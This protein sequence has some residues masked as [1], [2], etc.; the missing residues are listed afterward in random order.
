MHERC[1]L[2]N[3]HVGL[4]GIPR[5]ISFWRRLES[6][7]LSVSISAPGWGAQRG[8]G[9]TN[10]DFLKQLKQRGIRTRYKRCFSCNEVERA[11]CC[12]GIQTWKN[13]VIRV[14]RSKREFQFAA[15]VRFSA[16]I[17]WVLLRH[18][19]DCKMVLELTDFAQ[20]KF[21]SLKKDLTN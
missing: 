5:K 16:G 12:S 20:G 15:G 6:V 4:L 21:F 19:P 3:A 1:I 18:A 13:N 9:F 11:S 7:F 14:C 10:L 17:S 2:K 8:Y